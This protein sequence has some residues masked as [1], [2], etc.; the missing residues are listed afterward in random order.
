[1]EP[2]GDFGPHLHNFY[3]YAHYRPITASGAMRIARSPQELVGHV[4]AYR[5]DR[6]LDREKRAQLVR[7]MVGDDPRGS[8]DRIAEAIGDLADSR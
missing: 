1:V 5:A 4:R 8:V 2:Y 6:T 7:D 3:D